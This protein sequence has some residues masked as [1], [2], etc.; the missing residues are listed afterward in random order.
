MTGSQPLAGK[1]ALVTGAGRGIGRAHA[2]ALAEAGAAVVVNDL[3]GGFKG[4]GA[5]PATASAVVAEIEALGGRAVADTGNVADWTAAKA[6]VEAAITAFG[7]IDIVVNNAGICRFAETDTMT[8]EDWDLTIAVNLTGT[9]AVSHWAARHWRA[10]G[11]GAGRAIINTSSP[12][13]TN[14]A[15][16]SPS[17]CASK[18]G[19]AAFTIAAAT[20]LAGLGVR[21]NAIAPMARTRMTLDVPALDEIMKP[22]ET[23]FDRVAPEHVSP[24]VVWL[25]SPQCRFTGRVFGIEGDDLFLFEG[26]SAEHH[27]N[28]DGRPWSA[29]AIESR[30]AEFDRQDRGWMIA[31]SV[32][33]PGPSPSDETLAALERVA[34]PST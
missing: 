21:V 9:A 22:V 29:A 23:D 16:G 14:P 20:E 26:W 11:P 31:P 34:A 27:L 10:I 2:L 5:D 19:V 17:Y 1:V 18:A 32:R 28:N 15:P 7:R 6:M 12:A 3:G 24:L 25:A 30:L 13:G 8:P 4:E 33:L